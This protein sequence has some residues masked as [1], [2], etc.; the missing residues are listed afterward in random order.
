MIEIIQQLPV[1]AQIPIALIIGLLVF[2][3][4]FGGSALCLWF[5]FETEWGSTILLGFAIAFFCYTLG[6]SILKEHGVILPPYTRS[7]G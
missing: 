5:V 7:L 3:L 2:S 6:A 1:A 4:F